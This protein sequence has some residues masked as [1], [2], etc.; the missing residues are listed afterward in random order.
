VN[1]VDK[2]VGVS[3]DDVHSIHNVTIVVCWKGSRG[4]SC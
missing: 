1:C 2:V 4:E 3:D